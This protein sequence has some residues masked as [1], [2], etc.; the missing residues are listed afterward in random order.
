MHVFQP[1]P[2][3]AIEFDPFTKIGKDWGALTVTDGTKTNA[4]TIS[5]GSVGVMW[6]K[7]VFC[8]FVRDSR[9]SKEI[10]D[11]SDVFSVTFFE[12]KFKGAMKYLGAVSGR[13]EDKITNAR[14]NVNNNKGVPF[15]D[16]GNFVFICKKLSATP[17]TPDQFTDA[18]IEPAW[19]KDGDYHTM[20]IGEIMEILAR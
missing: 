18:G 9:Y 17:M 10:L 15:I 13:D 5:W 4:M 3:D 11:R 14:F 7:N 2:V 6:G 20:Y 12:S 1:Y 19:Y 16:E 8:C